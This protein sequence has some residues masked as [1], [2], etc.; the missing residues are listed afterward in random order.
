LYPTGL[1]YCTD[2]VNKYNVWIKSQQKHLPTFLLFG[3]I[4]TVATT[5]AAIG[6]VET[7]AVATK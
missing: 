3:R 7:T 2:N 6:E 1:S 5:V 4:S